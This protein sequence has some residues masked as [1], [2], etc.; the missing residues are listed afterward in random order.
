MTGVPEKPPPGGRQTRRRSHTPRCRPSSGAQLT[1]FPTTQTP[2]GCTNR[3]IGAARGCFSLTPTRSRHRRRPLRGSRRRLRPTTFQRGR[4]RHPRRS[5]NS[6][7]A[8][9]LSLKERERPPRVPSLSPLPVA[10]PRR[11]YS[12]RRDRTKAPRPNSLRP[13][14]QAFCR[15][16]YDA[17]AAAR[18]SAS[19]ADGSTPALPPAARPVGD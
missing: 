18:P 14:R 11:S 6:G 9:V 3:P 12:R 16:V 1:L 4:R 19:V 8:S 10:P 7:S 13:R 2:L 15:S 17:F 5:G